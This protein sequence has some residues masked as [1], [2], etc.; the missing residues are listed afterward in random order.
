MIAASPGATWTDNDSQDH[1]INVTCCKK[2][3]ALR[4]S[5]AYQTSLT[6]ER[7]GLSNTF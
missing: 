5:P 2:Y 3:G 7:T 4:F 6:Y 1:A